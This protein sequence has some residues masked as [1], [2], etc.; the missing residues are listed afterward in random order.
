MGYNL[1]KEIKEAIRA[2]EKALYSLKDAQKYLSK[3]STWGVV[4]IL[5]GGLFTDIMKHSNI[6]EAS[7][8]MDEAKRDL[9]RFSKELDDIDEYLP[10]INMGEFLTFADFF[11]DG[12]VA[13]V[14]MQSRISEAEKQVEDAIRQVNGILKRLKKE[15]YK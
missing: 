2:G 11:F 7:D 1:K 4:D 9:K 12:F 3:A 8:C 13:D 15:L 6:R 14:F 10:D 5:G